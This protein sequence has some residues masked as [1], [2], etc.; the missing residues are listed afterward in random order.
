MV[1]ERF[2][3]TFPFCS[4]CQFIPAAAVI[5]QSADV[6]FNAVSSSSTSLEILDVPE[7]HRK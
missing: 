6:I 1:R 5:G 7:T 2:L 3:K 4:R